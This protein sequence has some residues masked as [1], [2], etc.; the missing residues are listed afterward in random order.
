M[1]AISHHVKILN[2]ITVTWKCI[3]IE[4]HNTFWLMQIVTLQLSNYHIRFLR[5]KIIAFGSQEANDFELCDGLWLTR[6]K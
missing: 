6:S 5:H 2:H 4:S 3:I 1:I